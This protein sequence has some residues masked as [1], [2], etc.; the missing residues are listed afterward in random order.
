MLKH[1]VMYSLKQHW[2]CTYCNCY[3]STYIWILLK[4]KE[5]PW[6]QYIKIFI[7]RYLWEEKSE[8]SNQRERMAKVEIKTL[9]SHFTAERWLRYPPPFPYLAWASTHPEKAQIELVFIWDALTLVNCGR[10]RTA[11]VKGSVQLC[12]HASSVGACSY[13]FLRS[14]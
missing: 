3:H 14:R 6:V 2:K 12:S 10:E 11:Q 9:L 4:G 13:D 7:Y 5:P 8:D 1:E